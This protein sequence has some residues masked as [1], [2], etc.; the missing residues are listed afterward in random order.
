MWQF[1]PFRLTACQ[2]PDLDD[3]L[4]ADAG[5][6]EATVAADGERTTHSPQDLRTD[7]RKAKF[8]RVGIADIDRV[9]VDEGHYSRAVGCVLNRRVGPAFVRV[10]SLRHIEDLRSVLRVDHD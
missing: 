1:D 2:I 9:T 10:R 6:Q 7:H 5:C 3:V 8:A 4:V